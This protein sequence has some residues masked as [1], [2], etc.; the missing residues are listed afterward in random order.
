MFSVLTTSEEFKNGGFTLKP[1]QI[2][3]V[4][5]TPEE[6]KNATITGQFGFVFEEASVWGIH[7]YRAVI[8]FEKFCSQNVLSSHHNPKPAFS[9][10]SSLKS[11]FEK[12]HFRDGSVQTVG[13]TVEIKLRLCQIQT[14]N[15][16]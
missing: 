15:D 3:S 6:F 10:S 5:T 2:F 14:R 16:R 13:L 7:N 12:P 9:N 8:V 1:H 11:V 4:H